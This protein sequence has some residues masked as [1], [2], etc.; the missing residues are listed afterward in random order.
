MMDGIP[1]FVLGR[2]MDMHGDKLINHPVAGPLEFR[3]ETLALPDDPDQ[4]IVAYTVE[5]S[6]FSN[7]WWAYRSSLNAGTSW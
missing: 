1:A 6:R 4:V 5:P 2:R 7:Q 3:Y